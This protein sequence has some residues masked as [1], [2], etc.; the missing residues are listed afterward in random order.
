[1]GDLRAG[2]HG[3]FHRPAFDSDPAIFG[4]NHAVTVNRSTDGGATWSA[5]IALL[6]ENDPDIFNDKE[7]GTADPTS[8]NRVYATWDRLER[9]A[10][11]S[12]WH[13]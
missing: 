8:A 9:A 4:G 6:A 2:R 11:D 12:W 10:T 1:V 7:S 5:P 13:G 3:L